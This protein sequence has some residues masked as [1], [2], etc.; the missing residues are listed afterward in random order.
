MNEV[1]IEIVAPINSIDQKKND[2]SH[3]LSEQTVQTILAGPDDHITLVETNS[4]ANNKGVMIL[5]PDWQQNAASPKAINHL[6]AQL[7]QQGWTTISIQPPNKPENYP[8]Q[9]INKEE[10]EKEK[11]RST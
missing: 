3:Y 6:R 4:T 11:H 2:L 8:S 7:P 1:K 9:A 5:L 10:R